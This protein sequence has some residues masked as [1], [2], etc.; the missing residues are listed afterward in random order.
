[1][2]LIINI[3]SVFSVLLFALN[4]NIANYILPYSINYDGCTAIR[5]N[6]YALVIALFSICSL[7]EQT[8]FSK[9][10]LTIGIGFCVS[11]VIDR[12]IFNETDFKLIGDSIMILATIITALYKYVN[13][14]S[15]KP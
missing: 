13:S 1:M 6:I 7:L 10:I 14:G 2:K 3:L 15:N 9:M 5:Y 12:F 11:D 4:Y 8:K